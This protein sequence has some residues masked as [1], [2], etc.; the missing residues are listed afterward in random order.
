MI[1]NPRI[2]LHRLVLSLSEALDCV[3]PRISDHQKRVAYIATRVAQAMGLAGEDLLDV[4]LAAALHDVGIVGVEN[5]REALEMGH[6]E[7]VSWH[8]ELGHRLLADN[9]LL[10]RAAEQVRYHHVPWDNGAGACRDGQPVPAATHIL[11]LADVVERMIQRG[12]PILTQ[13]GTIL[14]EVASLSGKVFKPD[15]AEALGSVAGPEAFW[16]DV[17]SPRIYSILLGEMD[18]PTLSIDETT[19]GP[20]GE[21]FARVVDSASEWTAVHSAGVAATAVALAER[22]NFSPREL[23]LMR[24]AGYLHDLGKLSVPT[25]ILDKPARLTKEEMLVMR[26]H[27]YY[28]FRILDT[29]GGMPQISEWAAFHHERLDGGGYP[30]HHGADELTLGSRIMAVA[31]VFTALRERRPYRPRSMPMADAQAILGKLVQSNGLDG[32]VVAALDGG[33]EAIDATRAAE[34]TAYGATQRDLMALMG[35][36]AIA[37]TWSRDIAVGATP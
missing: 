4:F 9:P 25:A 11:V 6:M 14:A 22:M 33:I 27:T 20:I 8:G 23:H 1:I 2:P 32:D 36:P 10:A 3:N 24:A 18:W 21:I 31:D 26:G 7:R 19:I 13:T 5:R 35:R 17:V 30:F 37:D 16:L 28:T 29:I 12:R 34:Q 15:C